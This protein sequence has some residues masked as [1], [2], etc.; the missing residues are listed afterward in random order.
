[1]DIRTRGP[2]VPVHLGKYMYDLLCND[3]LC[4]IN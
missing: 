4:T 3:Q 2:R 1:M